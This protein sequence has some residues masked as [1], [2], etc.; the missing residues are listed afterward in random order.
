V[1][2]HS[3]AIPPPEPP[4]GATLAALV[5]AFDRNPRIKEAWLTGERLTPEDGSPAWDATNIVLVLDPPVPR[6]PFDKLRGEVAALERE[7]EPV[8]FHRDPDRLWE[9]SDHDAIRWVRKDAVRIYPLDREP[10]SA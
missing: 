9:F 7:L 1:R 3:E 4:D 8:G 2:I 5:D 10:R 6:E